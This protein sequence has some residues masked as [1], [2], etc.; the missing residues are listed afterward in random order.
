MMIVDILAGLI[1][2]MEIGLIVYVGY[3]FYG[4]FIR[5]GSSALHY[6]IEWA[7]PYVSLTFGLRIDERSFSTALEAAL[8]AYGGTLVAEAM[9]LCVFFYCCCC[10]CVPAEYKLRNSTSRPILPPPSVLEQ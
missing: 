1:K 9:L 8:S 10:F 7:S 4:I 2:P 6:L 5:S 3:A